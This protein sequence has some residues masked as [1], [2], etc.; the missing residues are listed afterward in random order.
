[1]TW[2]INFFKN[3]NQT[4]EKKEFN[5]VNFVGSVGVHKN[6]FLILAMSKMKK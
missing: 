2:T 6:P 5:R 3:Q 4:V 1:M